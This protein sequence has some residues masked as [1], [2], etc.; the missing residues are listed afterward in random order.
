[1]STNLRIAVVGSGYVG[2]VSGACLAD[3]GHSVMCVDNDAKRIA[4]LCRLEM[5][6]YEPGLA[7]LVTRAVEAGRLTFG[8]DL[9]AAV[10][11]ADIVLVAVGTP[12]RRSDGF[13]DLTQVFGVARDIAKHLTDFTV[14]VVK[15]TVPLGTGDEVERIIRSENPHAQFAVASNPEFLREGSAID[16]FNKPDR[17]VIG[18][19][20]KRARDVLIDLYRPLSARGVPVLI[21]ERR[22]SELIK[23]ATNAFLALKLTFIN[24]MADLCER[25]GVDVLEVARGIGSD[26]TGRAEIP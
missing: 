4:A 2:L 24:E 23:Y 21:T 18:I 19:E 26:S 10:A 1:M 25:V 14:V 20:D 22:A 9:A 3:F 12:P 15:S 11:G 13:A 6:I 16:D 7:E 5:P 8:R 17:I